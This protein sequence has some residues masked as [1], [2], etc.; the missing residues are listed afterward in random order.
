M[1][2]VILTS[3]RTNINPK[4]GKGLRFKDR[5]GHR[6]GRLVFIEL[7]GKSAHG[8]HIWKAQCDCGKETFTATPH[9]T[10]SCG[11]L[12]NEAASKTQ[13][14]KKLSPEKKL[15]S[16]R[17]SASNQ[18]LKR[19]LC[20][21]KSMHARLSRLHRHALAQVNAIKTSSTFDALGYTPAEFKAH[22]EKQFING[23]G[24]WNM[25]DWQIDHIIPISTAKNEQ[26]VIALNQLSNLRPMW[27]SLN[28][29]KKS[30]VETLL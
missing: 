28:N 30:R 29:K 3:K 6:N 5:S 1:A 2:D 15:E 25:K 9:K 26:D 13:L 11:C 24:W 16:R 10:K 21:I 14:S 20:H 27:S 4:T 12:R 17:R 22:I 8:H 7:I 19:K 23:M 18:R